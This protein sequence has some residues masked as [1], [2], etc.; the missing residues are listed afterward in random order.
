MKPPLLVYHLAEADNWVTIQQHGL[1]SARALLDQAGVVGGERD[2][3]ERQQRL[4]H[5][6][7]SSGA[8]IRDQ[9]PM[10]PTA[11]ARCLVGMTPAQW[12]AEINRRVFFWLTPERLNRHRKALEP[13]PQVVLTMDARRLVE[14]YAESVAMT[15]INTGN[16]RRRPAQRGAATF[17]PFSQWIVSGWASEAAGLGTSARPRSQPAVELTL[18]SSVPDL[19]PFVLKVQELATGQSFVP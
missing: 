10:P 4:Q 12:Y 5:T 2:R 17:V 18:A 11:L 7:L 8:Q 16:A 1:H 3:L 19:L 13:R 6:V 9:R 14:A 15:P